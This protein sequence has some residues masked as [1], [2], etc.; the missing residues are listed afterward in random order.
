MTYTVT[1]GLDEETDDTHHARVTDADQMDHLLDTIAA[2][3]GDGGAPF[4]VTIVADDDPDAH[5]ALQLGVGHPDRAFV[6]CLGDHGGY[7]YEPDL[8]PWSE[9][10]TFNYHGE[11]T[12]YGPNRTRTTPAVAREAAR[13]YVTTGNRPATAKLDPDA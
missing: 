8:P 2:T 9:P 13:Q 3:R 10:I 1:W 5:R 4:A 7:A 6:L 11:P 12:E